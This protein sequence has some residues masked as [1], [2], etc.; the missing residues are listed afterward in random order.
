MTNMVDY[1]EE[2]IDTVCYLTNPMLLSIK[3]KRDCN[4]G[5][6]AMLK[7]LSKCESEI[8]R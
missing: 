1:I 3:N 4:N 5:S 2:L 6:Y 8:E 7:K